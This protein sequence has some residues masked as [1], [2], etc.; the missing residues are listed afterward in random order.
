MMRALGGWFYVQNHESCLS[1]QNGLA[2]DGEV[3]IATCHGIRG[4]SA[5]VVERGLITEG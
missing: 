3:A 2:E 4:R 5:V 1:G